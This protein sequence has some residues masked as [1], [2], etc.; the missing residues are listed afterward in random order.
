MLK[1]Q[2]PN[3]YMF[4]EIKDWKFTGNLKL[5]LVTSKKD[6]DQILRSIL[7]SDEFSK[8]EDNNQAE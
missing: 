3:F 4:W 6:L 7:N 2:N 8:F 1:Q 5:E